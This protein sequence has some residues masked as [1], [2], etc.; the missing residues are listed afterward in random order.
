MAT[1]RLNDA[2]SARLTDLTLAHVQAQQAGAPS[3]APE[4]LQERAADSCAPAVVKMQVKICHAKAHVVVLEKQ[5]KAIK[6]KEQQ[7]RQWLRTL[8]LFLTNLSK[9]KAPANDLVW[10]NFQQQKVLKTIEKNGL[11]EQIKLELKIETE[12]SKGHHLQ[13]VDKKT[14]EALS[15]SSTGTSGSRCRHRSKRSNLVCQVIK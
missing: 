10:F 15:R 4:K 6:E 5:L 1:G 9:T 2:A 3:P 8:D 7:G 11:T 12:K 14:V 13:E